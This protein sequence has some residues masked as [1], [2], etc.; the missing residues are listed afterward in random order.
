LHGPGEDA[1]TGRRR[2]TTRWPP[3]PLELEL[4]LRQQRPRDRC[5]PPHT[6]RGGWTWYTGSASWLH[7]VAVEAIL[8]IRPSDDTLRVEP[9]ISSRWSGYEVAYHRGSAIYRIRV[10]N[11]AGANRGVRSV[12]VDGQ[13]VPGGV[14]PLRDDGRAHDVRVTLGHGE[15]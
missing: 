11:P 13:P 9:C 8:G 14:V 2:G 12:L 3:R 7:R 6:G 5:A 4:L 10:E 15:R 1:L